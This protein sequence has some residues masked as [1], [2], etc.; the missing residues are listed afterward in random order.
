[1]TEAPEIFISHSIISNSKRVNGSKDHFRQAIIGLIHAGHVVAAY[2]QTTD[3]PTIVFRDAA[4]FEYWYDNFARIQGWVVP[5][6]PQQT[7]RD[8]TDYFNCARIE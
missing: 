4:S 8:V 5:E 7:Q 2:E 6:L 3:R 1:M